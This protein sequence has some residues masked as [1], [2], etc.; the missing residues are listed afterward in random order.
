[1]ILS[2]WFS[3]VL[4]PNSSKVVKHVGAGLSFAMTVLIG[5]FVGFWVDKRWG[6]SPWGLVGGSAAGFGLGLY[7]FIREFTDTTN[8]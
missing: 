5:V 4:S 2:K 7:N 6:V 8:A 3:Y 1:M